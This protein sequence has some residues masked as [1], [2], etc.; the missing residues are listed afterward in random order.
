MVVYGGC[1]RV[2]HISYVTLD[3]EHIFLRDT[4]PGVH[5]SVHGC[6]RKN[7]RRCGNLD[8]IPTTPR[9]WLGT[10]RTHCLVDSGYMFCV[11]L[12]ASGSLAHI[13]YV[14]GNSDPEVNTCPALRRAEVC[15]VDAFM[16]LLYLTVIWSPLGHC[17]RRVFQPSMTHSCD[18]SRAG[19]WRGRWES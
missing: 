10:L 5:S 14:K 11:F 18:S 4:H 2:P 7:S 19:G 13:F 8:I 15:A 6:F 1:G 9:I 17:L 12:G 16:S 3:L